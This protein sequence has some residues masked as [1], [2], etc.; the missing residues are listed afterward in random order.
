MEIKKRTYRFAGREANPSKVKGLPGLTGV[1]D[2]DTATWFQESWLIS[3]S[4]GQ[5]K[6][7]AFRT[8]EEGAGLLGS[9]NWYDV[10]LIPEDIRLELQ[11]IDRAIKELRVNRQNLLEEHFSEWTPVT[12]EDCDRIAPEK[13]TSKSQA[14]E[15]VR[16]R[17]RTFKLDPTAKAKEKDEIRTVSQVNRMISETF[18]K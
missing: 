11:N 18:L 8:F 9:R 3:R 10:R 17:N 12:K 13:A 16:E 15:Q 7:E 4:L 1:R 6:F 2:Y 14:M 5:A